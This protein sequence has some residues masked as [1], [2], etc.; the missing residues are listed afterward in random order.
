[1]QNVLEFIRYLFEYFPMLPIIILGHRYVN[2]IKVQNLLCLII[3]FCQQHQL[4]LHL[5]FN[6]L[7]V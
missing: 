6:I 2:Y 4:L 5:L 7:D 1:M 3:E